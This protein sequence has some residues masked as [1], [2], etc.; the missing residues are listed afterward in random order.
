MVRDFAGHVVINTT[1]DTRMPL[2]EVI[3]PKKPKVSLYHDVSFP[4]QNIKVT[5]KGKTIIFGEKM[6][7]LSLTK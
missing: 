6:K 7:N 3:A 4:F 2:G 1:M 5:V